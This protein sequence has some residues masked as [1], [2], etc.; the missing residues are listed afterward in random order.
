VHFDPALN[1]ETWLPR[2]R[3]FSHPARS[4]AATTSHPEHTGNFAISANLLP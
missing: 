2:C 3:F 1:I 4:N